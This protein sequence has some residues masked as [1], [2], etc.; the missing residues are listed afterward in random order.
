MSKERLLTESSF[1][2]SETDEKGIISFA[3]DDFCNYAGYTIDELIGKPHNIVRNP[4]MPKEAF[5]QLWETIK[6]GK[7]WKGFVKNRSKNGDYY[8][9]HA[10]IYPMTISNGEK[11]YMSCRRMATKEEIK[12]A[13]LLYGTLN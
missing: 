6:S 4:D 11:G 7:T 10:T 1:L 13:E 3:N 2:V 8:W 5:K 12:S 9:V